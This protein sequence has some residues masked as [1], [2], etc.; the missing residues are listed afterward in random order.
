M[1]LN[2]AP[3]DLI[4]KDYITYYLQKYRNKNDL[5]YNK[6][7]SYHKLIELLLKL[8]F[9]E[10]K[11]MKGLLMK[12]LWIESNINYILTI[13]RIF[14]ISMPIFNN[15]DSN[16]YNKIEKLINEK[17]IKYLTYESKNPEYIKEV[18]EC[19]YILL[20]SICYCVT[21]DE[22]K[23]IA[24]LNNKNNNTIEI[25]HYLYIL[26][27]INKILQNLKDELNIYLNEMYIIDELIKIIEIFIKK[28][29]IEKI[30]E[31][32]NLMR[33]NALNIQK[34]S[35]NEKNL[36]KELINNFEE[37]Y[38][39][40]IKDEII[41]KNDKYYYDKV[42]YILFT[43]IKKVPNID[44]RYKILEKLLE[45]NEMIKKSNDIFQIL[46]KNM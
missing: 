17:K 16:F 19:Y 32:K 2:K 7:D 45:S 33:E 30:N 11:N 41:D 26:K 9:K 13:L 27:D 22:I 38:N 44:F 1:I 8:R 3:N 5:D 31:I 40:I 46:L 12:I 4:F 29:N 43:E 25:T 18:N 14:D 21:S 35:N 20:E 10:D 15:N 37:I 23:L 34:N 39:L 6:D 28:Q 24:S 42:R 36:S